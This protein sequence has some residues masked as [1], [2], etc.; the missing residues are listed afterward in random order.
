MKSKHVC[1]S[2][3]EKIHHQ[4]KNELIPQ[5][6][7]L[8]KKKK[9]KRWIISVILNINHHGELDPRKLTIR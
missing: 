4:D 9:M 2:V 3:R 6:G 1:A 8:K 7:T 5:V